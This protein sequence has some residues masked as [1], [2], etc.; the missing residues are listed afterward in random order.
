M[1]KKR[2]IER[3]RLAEQY[4]LSDSSWMVKKNSVYLYENIF[5]LN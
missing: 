1:T 4:K 2:Q 3:F 5:N